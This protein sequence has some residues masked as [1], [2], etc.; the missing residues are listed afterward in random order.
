MVLTSRGVLKYALIS[1][2]RFSLLA[3][4]NDAARGEQRH[5]ARTL[6]ETVPVEFRIVVVACP[7]TNCIDVTAE[8][9]RPATSEL[10]V[11]FQMQ[12]GLAK[13]IRDA[14]R[15]FGSKRFSIYGG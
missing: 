14:F 12:I 7:C 6:A 9:L 10:R 5:R 13:T 1:R 4:A 8:N 11:L 15:K 3:T 2:V